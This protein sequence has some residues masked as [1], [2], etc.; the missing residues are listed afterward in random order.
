MLKRRFSPKDIPDLG[1]W[2]RA[3]QGLT[4]VDGKVSQWDDLSGNSRHLAQSTDGRRPTYEATGLNGNPTV[5]FNA[6]HILYR[7][8]DSLVRNVNGAT[9]IAAFKSA[10]TKTAGQCLFYFDTNT[11]TQRITSWQ[12]ANSTE[13]NV[14]GRRLDEDSVDASDSY[15][16]YFEGSVAHV[17]VWIP[18][19]A[20]ASLYMRR[21]GSQVVGDTSWTSA[22]Y[23]SDTDSL[24]IEVGAHGAVQWPLYG[25]L[26]EFLVYRRKLT[27]GELESVEHYLGAQYG[28][29]VA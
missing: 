12:A 22:G 2:L 4:L 29:T 21:G 26:S 11:S 3:D 8:N 15:A 7:S 17:Y 16:G 5:Y 25:R 18:D 27:S 24:A 13:A 19:W 23:T 10:G 20:N 14:Y 6:A 28:I 9:I 1:L